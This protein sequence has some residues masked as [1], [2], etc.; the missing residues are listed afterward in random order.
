MFEFEDVELLGE[1]QA[2]GAGDDWTFRASSTTII[3]PK[4]RRIVDDTPWI[5]TL[6]GTFELGAPA[7]VAE[8]SPVV[9]RTTTSAT[10]VDDGRTIDC[11]LP[12][13][14]TPGFGLGRVSVT[15]GWDETRNRVK[16]IWNLYTG[17]WSCDGPFVPSCERVKTQDG[18]ITY[19]KEIEFT[20]RN[21]RLPVELGHRTT[22]DVTCT[23]R[24]NGYVRLKKLRDGR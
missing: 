4:R 14:L 9:W 1:M 20:R 2:S 17:G 16:A 6:D 24:W 3:S 19:Y 8:A 15:F 22:D 10:L 12:P 18:N 11:T 5:T 7:V 21:I 23:T 13:L